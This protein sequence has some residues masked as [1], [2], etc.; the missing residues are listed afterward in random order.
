M[1]L[2]HEESDKFLIRIVA[3][4]ALHSSGLS[5]IQAKKYWD[6]TLWVLKYQSS[7]SGREDFAIPDMP[8]KSGPE[9]Q[10]CLL[11]YNSADRPYYWKIFKIYRISEHRP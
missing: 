6:I 1:K 3:L 4:R 11:Y 9:H 7:R 2:S 8:M 10:V 5:S